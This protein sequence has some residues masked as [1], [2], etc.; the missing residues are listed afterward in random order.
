V[1][2]LIMVLVLLAPDLLNLSREQARLLE[3][4]DWF[5]YGCFAVDFLLKLYL[6]PSVRGHL[7][8]N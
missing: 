8:R 1:L 3:I 5:I 4:V 7:K 6:A 2:A